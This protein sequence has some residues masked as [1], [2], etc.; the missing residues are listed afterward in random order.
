MT[1]HFRDC[2]HKFGFVLCG[3]TTTKRADF[4]GW[5]FGTVV[6]LD[7]NLDVSGVGDGL[8]G[9]ETDRNQQ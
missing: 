4:D 1:F 6:R 7:L 3:Q 2:R 9:R 5:A 8:A